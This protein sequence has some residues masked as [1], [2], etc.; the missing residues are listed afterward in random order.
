MARAGIQV[1]LNVREI[2]E[3]C[4]PKCRKKIRQ[5]I[6]DKISEDMVSKVIG[7]PEERR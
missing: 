7:L 2:Y 6:R 4:C 3:K 1:Q 5:L